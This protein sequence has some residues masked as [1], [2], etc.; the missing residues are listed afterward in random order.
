[1]LKIGIVVGS[2]RKGRVGRKVAEWLLNHARKR[3]D[4]AVYTLIDLVDYPLPF[5]GAELPADQQQ[6]ADEAIRAWSSWACLHCC[7]S[8]EQAA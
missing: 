2:T 5:Y 8:P 6:V 4:H 3:N 1:M 7:S